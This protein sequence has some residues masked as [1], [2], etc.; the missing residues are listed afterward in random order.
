ME[1]RLGGG[2]AR[3]GRKIAAQHQ[4]IT[5]TTA[6]P[7][8]WA[9][10]EGLALGE[11]WRAAHRERYVASRARLAGGLERRALPCC[12]GRAPGL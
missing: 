6:T 3:A 7:L 8:Q 11:P 9:V 2:G 4:F 1:D 12:R 5:L 10:A